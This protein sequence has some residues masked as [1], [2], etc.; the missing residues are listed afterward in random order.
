MRLVRRWHQLRVYSIVLLVVGRG[1]SACDDTGGP[2]PG[3]PSTGTLVVSTS[4]EGDDPDQD[5]YLL[6]VDGVDSL[7]L[8]PTGIAPRS[9]SHLAGI[10]CDCSAWRSIAR[11]P[12]EPRSTWM[13]LRQARLRWPSKSIVSATGARVTVTTTGLDFDPDGYR[14]DGGR[15][16]PRGPSLERHGP[17]SARS[18]KPDDCPDRTFSPNCAVDGPGS[19]TVTIVQTE[20]A[21]VD[22]AVACTATSGVIRVVLQDSGSDGT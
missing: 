13:S 20:V 3:G 12:R 9:T 16:R 17:Y 22:F 4:T 1:L 10:P 18:G 8:D 7:D 2:E 19:R 5:G 15:D 14:A 6:T 21:P 11:W